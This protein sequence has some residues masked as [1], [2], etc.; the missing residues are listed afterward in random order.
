MTI[1]SY[2]SMA[3][4]NT[5]GAG[6]LIVPWAYVDI[7]LPNRTGQGHLLNL[8]TKAWSRTPYLV[9]GPRCNSA[10]NPN[11]GA[12]YIYPDYQ[13]ADSNVICRVNSDNTVTTYGAPPQMLIYFWTCI[14]TTRNYFWIGGI[15]GSG[16]SRIIAYNCANMGAGPAV[17]VTLSVFV[18]GQTVSAD[19][20]PQLDR[21]VGVSSSSTIRTLNPASP[22]S[23]WATS[24][25]SGSP[26]APNNGMLSKY[27]YY[28][29][30]K[31]FLGASKTSDRAWAYRVVA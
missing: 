20:V 30:L 14:D 11:D 8:T 16:Q 21:I 4:L 10:Y 12:C 1:H 5:G 13:T 6:S 23:G 3:F 26:P 24:S 17:D 9:A 19:Y 7:D 28:P 29:L 27:R 18:D 2:Y 31:C 22:S 25:A 15:N